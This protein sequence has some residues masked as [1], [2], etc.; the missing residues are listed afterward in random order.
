MNCHV[1]YEN[2]IFRSC[3]K[4]KRGVRSEMRKMTVDES[5]TRKEKAIMA[6]EVFCTCISDNDM[7]GS[8]RID[9]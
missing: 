6:G 9:E 3:G 7:A 2:K 8:R 5:D 4:I 1:V